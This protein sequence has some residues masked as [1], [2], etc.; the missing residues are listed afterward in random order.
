MTYDSFK[1]GASLVFTD[2]PPAAREG[3]SRPVAESV[4]EVMER[5]PIG[6][7]NDIV[8]A[9]LAK[10][11][12]DAM[13]PMSAIGLAIPSVVNFR[14]FTQ[15]GR[16]PATAAGVSPRRAGLWG[17]HHDE[18]LPF[19]PPAEVPLSPG[20]AG[21]DNGAANQ[22]L[23]VAHLFTDLQ[24]HVP[25]VLFNISS[26]QNVAANVGGDMFQHEERRGNVMVSTYGQTLMLTVEALVVAADDS[27]AGQLLA[28][29]DACFSLFRHQIGTGHTI[30]GPSW[31]LHM[32]T[33]VATSSI[34]KQE[35][36][37][38]NG[39]DKGG[40]IYTSVATLENVLFE[41]F[42][43][44]EQA[45]DFSLPSFSDE[46]AGDPSISVN[47]DQ[48]EDIVMR[49]G[50]TRR[51]TVNNAPVAS[52]LLVSQKKRIIDLKPPGAIPSYMITARRTG[53]AVLAL[54]AT[55]G[56]TLVT[57]GPTNEIIG[58]APLTQ[59]RIIVTA[60]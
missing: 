49:L 1:T 11:L 43:S 17:E 21:E 30:A 57:D 18:R 54:W 14:A 6:F 35:A 50:E 34:D 3:F 45:I 29:V 36:P 24:A 37:W 40:D 32:P 46:P 38:A 28:C 42:V 33:M 5:N 8:Y 10:R 16:Q 26:R 27:S 7:V 22:G 23:V 9:A 60:V 15:G 12:R 48:T 59:R 53:E 39:D 52:E 55:S 13:D 2:T 4:T 19:M 58:N 44:Y 25:L 20:I 31:R 51:V 41:G 56:P 47:N